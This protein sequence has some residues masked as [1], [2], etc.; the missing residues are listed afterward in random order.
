MP[1][2][3]GSSWIS[4][5]GKVFGSSGSWLSTR[6]GPFWKRSGRLPIVT[7][8][9]CLVIAQNGMPFVR[10]NQWTGS[11]WRK[12]FHSGCGYPRSA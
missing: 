9:A 11:S 3:G 6:R 2:F 5:G 12:R 4:V 8:S 1:C 7:M 10:S